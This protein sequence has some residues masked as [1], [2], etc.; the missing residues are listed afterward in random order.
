MNKLM[1]RS[2]PQLDARIDTMGARCQ[3]E[4]SKFRGNEPLKLVHF[5]VFSLV[6]QPFICGMQYTVTILRDFSK[7]VWV[8]LIKEKSNTFL[9]FKDLD[10]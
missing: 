10:I 1:L 2:L 9:K 3:Y 5:D 8:F 4:E 6:K 7:Y